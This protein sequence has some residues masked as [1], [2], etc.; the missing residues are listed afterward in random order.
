MA[1]NRHII[2]RRLPERSKLMFY[3]PKPQDDFFVVHLPFF[4]NIK[5]KESK[6][7]KYQKYSPISRSS[8]LYTYLGADSRKIDLQFSMTL[9]HILEEYP[10][11]N[12]DKYI[13]EAKQDFGTITKE[14]FKGSD[15]RQAADQAATYYD[16]FF[17]SN[18]ELKESAKQVLNASVFGEKGIKNTEVEYLKSLYDLKD[19][20]GLDQAQADLA[21][22]GLFGKLA[23]LGITTASEIGETQKVRLNIINTIIYW[24]NIIRASVMNNAQNPLFGPPV[25]RLQHGVLYQDVPCI[26]TNYSVTWD[27]RMG[28][29]LQTMLP[30]RI[31]INLSLEEFRAGNFEEFSQSDIIKRDNLAGW[32]AIFDGT[33]SDSMDPGYGV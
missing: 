22:L 6:K 3:F 15:A 21:N 29:D 16:K 5:I 20:Q 31:N 10:Y 33:S 8:N 32:E 24:V 12:S 17:K 27:E 30:R 18:I 9:A 2:D 19:V 4:E 7:A 11:V 28:Y 23:G 14:S 13:L 26:A 25:I 1:G